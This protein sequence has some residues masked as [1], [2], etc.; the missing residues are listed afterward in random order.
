MDS[1]QEGFIDCHTHLADSVFEND[2]Q[3]VLDNARKSGVVAALVCTETPADIPIVLRL[4]EKF[5]DI[6]L[7]C[8]GIHPVQKDSNDVERCVSQKDLDKA[9][10][11]IEKRIDKI[12]AI[13]EVGLDFQPRITPNPEHK[14]AQRNVLKAQVELA[15]K[16][17]LPLNVHSR[18]AGR[19]AIAALKEFGARNVLM[20][21]FDGRPSIAMEGIKEGYFFSI[22]PSIVRSEQK[23]KLIKQLPMEQILLE[24]DSPALSPVK[25]ERNEPSNVKISC[26]HIANVKGL[27]SEEV[28][29]ITTQNAVKLFPKLK[30][31]LK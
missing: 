30:D 19:P 27:T 8:L 7:P 23:V 16:Y 31:I 15:N 12:C 6:L 1:R 3:D 26:D 10:S 24:T 9:I 11:E 5:P 17:N 28:R 29:R 2:I 13:G 14:E 18:S 21:A 20:H 25:G 4:C 22:P